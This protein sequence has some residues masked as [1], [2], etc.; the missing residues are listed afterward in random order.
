MTKLTTERLDKLQDSLLQ[1]QDSYSDP[2]DKENYGIFVIRCLRC[3]PC[4]T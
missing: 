2:A 3:P 1:F 4:Y